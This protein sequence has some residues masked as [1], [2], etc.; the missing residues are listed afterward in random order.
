MK[1]QSLLSQRALPL[2]VLDITTWP[3]INA[4]MLT[5]A[6]KDRYERFRKAITRIVRDHATFSAAAREAGI[7]RSELDRAVERCLELAFD[8]KIEGW[9]ALIPYRRL[10]PYHR[11]PETKGG[12]AGILQALLDKFPAINEALWTGYQQGKSLKELQERL[13]NELLPQVNW[14]RHLYPYNTV[15]KARE[16]LRQYLRRMEIEKRAAGWGE[17]DFSEERRIT[18]RPFERVELDAHRCDAHF[19]IHI[20]GPEG[21]S[22]T[23]VLE[24]IWLLVVIDVGSRAVLGYALSLNRQCNISDVLEAIHTA[25]VP[26]SPRIL[27]IPGLAYKPGAG[28]PNWS[29]LACAWQLFDLIAL[30]NAMAHRSPRLHDILNERTQCAVKLNRAGKPNDNTFI[31]RFFGTLTAHGLKRSPSTTGSGPDDPRRKD[32]EGQA[33]YYEF[34]LSDAEELLDVLIA[35][36]NAEGHRGLHTSPLDYLRTYYRET[37]ALTRHVPPSQRSSWTLRELW[38][39]ATIRGNVKEAERPYIQYL[40]ARYR[41]D[42]LGCSPEFIGQKLLLLV[43]VTDLRTLKAFLP[44]GRV[45][46]DLKVDGRWSLTKHSLKTRRLV[47]QLIREG[48]LQIGYQDPVSAVI[49]HLTTR[50]KESRSARNQL[51]R[52]QREMDKQPPATTTVEATAACMDYQPNREDWVSLRTPVYD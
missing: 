43:N 52:I 33:E 16:A 4:N 7:D 1:I 21:L 39:E 12:T 28:F 48:Q 24:R 44:D 38:V 25:I 50:S 41:S 6:A 5:P 40:D 17:Q 37:P 34:T 8:G 30:D 14:P 32:S 36:Y 10:K 19:V 18:L 3:E 2:T 23:A 22:R 15:T 20:D 29:I 46:G 49:N 45:F 47:I 42:L 31:E 11:R 27:T 9:R 51:A 26:Q 35:N 13:L